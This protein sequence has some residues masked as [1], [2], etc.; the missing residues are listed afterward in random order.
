MLQCEL[1]AAMKCGTEKSIICLEDKEF[2]SNVLWVEDLTE[3]SDRDPNFMQENRNVLWVCINGNLYRIEQR[4]AL[5][6]LN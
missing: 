6:N 3:I 1:Q 5:L 2:K 4:E